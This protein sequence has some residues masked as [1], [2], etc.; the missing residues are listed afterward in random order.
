M[1]AYRYKHEYLE[2]SLTTCQ[3]RKATKVVLSRAHDLPRHQLLPG[4]QYE[5]PPVK[6][7][8]SPI[9]KH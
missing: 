3:L 1:L 7:V 5:F 2:G 4:L 6:R 9:R 8:F